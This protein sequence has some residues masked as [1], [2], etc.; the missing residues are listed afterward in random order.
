[1]LTFLYRPLDIL[2]VFETAGQNGSTIGPASY[3]IRQALSQEYQKYVTCQR[4]DARQKRYNTG[5]GS[6]TE[7]DLGD[8]DKDSVSAETNGRKIDPVALKRDFFGRM[9]DAALPMGRSHSSR[10]GRAESQNSEL[11]S[12]GKGWKVWVSY[13]EGFSNAVRKPISLDELMRVF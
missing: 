5:R 7:A 2:G 11:D 10:A 6:G 12:K 9:V 13:H 1:M 4:A 8:K 3:A